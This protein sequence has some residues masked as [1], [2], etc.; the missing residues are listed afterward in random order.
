MGVSFRNDEPTEPQTP[1]SVFSWGDGDW[2]ASTDSSESSSSEGFEGDENS[3]PHVSTLP[4]KTTKMVDWSSPAK[5]K[6]ANGNE[7]AMKRDLAEVLRKGAQ[8]SRKLVEFFR[9][10]SPQNRPLFT[11]VAIAVATG[12]TTG[13]CSQHF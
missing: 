6:K 11:T 1:S 10:V 4:F 7:A 3:S 9:A 5:A 2:E 13:Y 8:H 12:A